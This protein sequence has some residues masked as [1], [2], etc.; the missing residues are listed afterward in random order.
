MRERAKME[1]GFP[2]R[3]SGVLC[4]ELQNTG[5]VRL[6]REAENSFDVELSGIEKL[7]GV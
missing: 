3:K 7:A 6:R 1:R 5:R 4:P 2:G